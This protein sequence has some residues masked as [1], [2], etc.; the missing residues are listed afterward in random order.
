[1]NKILIITAPSGAGKS[2]L[3][4]RLLQKFPKIRFSISACTRA[5]RG[6]EQNGVDYY[7][8]SVAD[9]QKKIDHNDFVEWEMVYEGKYYG[10]LK[11][12]LER[13]W[14][15]EELPLFDIDVRGALKVKELYGKAAVS[16]F[17]KAPSIAILRARLEARN[18]D[19]P[20][21][22]EERINKASLETSMAEQF[23][24]IVVND[25]LEEAVDQI[26]TIVQEIFANT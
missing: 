25:D 4:Q 8:M 16:I 10:T 5:P 9:F 21:A 24:H 7:F 12:E 22:I 17:I 1:M 18:T 20:E 15:N 26:S 14:D 13:I 3:T 23:D 11:S 2:T 6:K 19:S